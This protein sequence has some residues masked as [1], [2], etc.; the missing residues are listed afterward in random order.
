[1]E[2]EGHARGNIGTGRGMHAYAFDLRLE[3]GDRHLLRALVALAGAQAHR[4]HTAIY[5]HAKSEPVVSYQVSGGTRVR[6]DGKAEA[7]VRED[8]DV[9]YSDQG[10]LRPT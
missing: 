4:A 5:R 8:Q 2:G 10:G 9:A 3:E 6:R 7:C 1:M